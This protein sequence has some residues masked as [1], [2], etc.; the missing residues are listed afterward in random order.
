MPQGPVADA[1]YSGCAVAGTRHGGI[2]QM[3]P[4]W[5]D[6]P[7]HWSIQIPVPDVGACLARALALGGR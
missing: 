4:E 7:S 5:G 1:E 3:R 2:M 6:V